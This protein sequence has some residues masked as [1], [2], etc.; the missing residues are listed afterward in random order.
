MA[1]VTLQDLRGNPARARKEAVV[2]T[3]FLAAAVLS[4]VVSALIVIALVGKAWSF[5]GDVAQVVAVG[6]QLG[7][8]QR[9]TSRSRHCCRRRSW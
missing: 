1:A 8:S 6:R 3:M 9:A 5:F 2:K 7:A 4:V